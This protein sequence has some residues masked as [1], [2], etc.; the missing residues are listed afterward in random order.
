MRIGIL[1]GDKN[2]DYDLLNQE[3]WKMI[4]EKQCFLFDVI[5]SVYSES[6]GKVWA[7]NNGAP[8]VYLHERD[9]NKAI[10]KLFNMADFII[11]MNDN[12]QQMKNLIMQ[13]KMMGKHGCVLNI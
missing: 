8:L 5:V 2:K 4:E 11:F 7:D 1:G 13:Y 12:S 6:L 3:L 10:K 9:P